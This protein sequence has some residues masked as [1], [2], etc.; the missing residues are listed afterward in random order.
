MRQTKRTRQ[1]AARGLFVLAIGALATVSVGCRQQ[2][3][4][5]RSAASSRPRYFSSTL[6]HG[7]EK[8]NLEAVKRYLA[9]GPD[10][11]TFVGS[12]TLLHHAACD[13]RKQ[14]VQYLLDQ[15]ADINAAVKNGFTPI[16]VAAVQGH[17]DVVRWLAER[18]AVVSDA[19]TAAAA[20]HVDRLTQLAAEDPELLVKTWY[21]WA[22]SEE[23]TLLHHAA[24]HGSVESIAALVALGADPRAK[25][26]CG[27]T[28]LMI[29]AAGGHVEAV[30]ELLK[31]DHRINLASEYGRT[32]LNLA[33]NRGHEAVVTFLLERGA[34]YDIF[35]AVARG[36]LERVQTLVSQDKALLEE[37]SG[38]QTPLVWAAERNRPKILTWLLDQGAHLDFHNDWEDSALGAAAWN[39]HTEIVKL[40]LDGGANTEIGAG[41]DAYGTPLHRACCQG[42]LELVRMLLD[43]GAEINSENNS[44][45]TPLCFAVG[46]GRLDVVSYLLDRGAD[47]NKGAPLA[48]AA[49]EDRIEILQRLLE[50][51]ERLLERGAEVRMAL[52]RAA[53]RGTSRWFNDSSRTRWTGRCGTMS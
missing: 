13:G 40:L 29:A 1:P 34:R 46:E 4:E 51:A 7:I 23:H 8:G 12:M 26:S 35:T 27:F 20:N 31:H 48:D 52:H 37:E 21:T 28:P 2:Q 42:N 53:E 18:G 45:D 14:I 30:R 32:T 15:G 24:H 9:G 49:W 16:H 43:R 11:N 38:G 36:D 3:L 47:P 39:G 5:Q 41:E 25:D 19:P 44:H 10:I 6:L 22:W 17:T 33:A 50:I